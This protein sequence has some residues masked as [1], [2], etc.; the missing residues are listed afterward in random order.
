MTTATLKKENILVQYG[1][2]HSS[3]QADVEIDKVSPQHWNP[4]D[5]I[6]KAIVIK[7]IV[8]YLIPD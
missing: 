4:K 1:K 2:K 6:V 3:I 7:M 5:K 8:I